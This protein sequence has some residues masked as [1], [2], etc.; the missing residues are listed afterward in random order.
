MTVG[1]FVKS[2]GFKWERKHTQRAVA[3]GLGALPVSALAPG[4]VGAVE[5]VPGKRMRTAANVAGGT[6]LGGIAG[7]Q[8]TRFGANRL[9]MKR[10]LTL[11]AG[12]AS[13]HVP[14]GKL[15]AAGAVLGAGLGAAGGMMRAQDKGYVKKE[16]AVDLVELGQIAKAFRPH[17]NR[18]DIADV[19]VAGGGRAG[20]MYGHTSTVPASRTNRTWGGVAGGVNGVLAGTMGG[21]YV[22]GKMAARGAL[23]RNAKISAAGLR[24]VTD[25]G[26]RRGG[27]IGLAAGAA[28]GAAL[29]YAANRHERRFTPANAGGST[30]RQEAWRR[31]AYRDNTGD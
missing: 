11:K 27:K 28:G 1:Y 29:G 5:A 18:P 8:L 23:K 19:R 6:V 13:A 12:R 24:R 4:A 3:G 20:T 17:E 9:G 31:Y 22:G 21:A 25:I 16:F 14:K 15:M 10:G 7:R 30:T 2:D 26:A